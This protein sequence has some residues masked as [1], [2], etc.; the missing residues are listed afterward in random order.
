MRIRLVRPNSF[1]A[2][3][4]PILHIGYCIHFNYI[5]FHFLT[6][7]VAETNFAKETNPLSSRLGEIGRTKSVERSFTP[8]SKRNRHQ[9]L[10]K[11]TSRSKS[12]IIFFSYSSSKS[13]ANTYL[14]YRGKPYNLYSIR[15]TIRTLF[16]TILWPDY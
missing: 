13:F 5:Q 14:V 12:K 11:I 9:G 6:N 10:L 4:F 1:D 8:Q 15:Y 3:S 2:M 7:F 16:A